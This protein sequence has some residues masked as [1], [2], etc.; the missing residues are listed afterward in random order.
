MHESYEP[1]TAPVSTSETL[2]SHSSRLRANWAGEGSDD[3]TPTVTAGVFRMHREV[4]QLVRAGVAKAVR[5]RRTVISFET[6]KRR[7]D[8][9]DTPKSD[10]LI[11]VCP[12]IRIM[13]ALMPT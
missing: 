1:G 3:E 7:I 10:R 8:M 4:P 12:L 9:I 6:F 11:F 5:S 13:F 2:L